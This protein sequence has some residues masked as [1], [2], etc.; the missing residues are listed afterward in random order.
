[1]PTENVNLSYH[2]HTEDEIL[3]KRILERALTH[4]QK[5]YKFNRDLAS[6]EIYNDL[7]P[8]SER[9]SMS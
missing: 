5:K 4:F 6:F 8:P 2:N 9:V 7:F 1:M 3:A